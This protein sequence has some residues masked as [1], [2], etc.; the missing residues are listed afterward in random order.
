MR[1]TLA[2]V[3]T[4]T[5]LCSWYSQH[6]Q[7]PRLSPVEA[8]RPAPGGIDAWKGRTVRSQPHWGVGA[9][10]LPRGTHR[11]QERRKVN[12][13]SSCPTYQCI[14][15]SRALLHLLEKWVII[16]DL[17]CPFHEKRNSERNLQTGIG[18]R[19]V[20]FSRVVLKAELHLQAPG[21]SSR[22]TDCVRTPSFPVAKDFQ[23]PWKPR[24]LPG[25]TQS[26]GVRSRR[27]HPTLIRKGP[28]T[29]KL[30]T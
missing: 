13:L 11:S 10:L 16:Q 3:S 17:S 5:P 7:L 26:A 25:D 15:Q 21:T 14:N 22:T 18:I 2:K 29:H 23:R 9:E 12:M 20:S 19:A 6:L 28:S 4:Q 30:Q 27:E 24:V 8:R 1:S